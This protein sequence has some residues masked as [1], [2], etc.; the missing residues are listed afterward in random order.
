MPPK[1]SNPSLN[2]KFKKLNKK[3]CKLFNHCYRNGSMSG[4]DKSEIEALRAKYHDQIQIRRNEIQEFE[5]K[6][7]RLDE[8]ADDREKY[9]FVQKDKYRSLGLTAAVLDSIRALHA[10]GVAEKGGV[11]AGQVCDYL[12][13]HGFNFKTQNFT[14]S[15]Y[16]T[17]ERLS[18]AGKLSIAW[19]SGKKRF[20][21][22]DKILGTGGGLTGR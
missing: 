21:L 5:D 11:S 17:L 15:V 1:K 4:K 16:V 22:S 10:T 12:K 9:L 7:K 3:T 2:R 6:I 20:R 19:V 8:F 18:G 14:V 13:E